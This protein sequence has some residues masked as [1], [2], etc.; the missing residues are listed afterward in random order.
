MIHVCNL[1]TKEADYRI[2][3]CLKERGEERKAK[4]RSEERRGDPAEVL[5]KRY[6]NVYLDRG[7]LFFFLSFFPSLLP[8]FCVSV[9]CAHVCVQEYTLGHQGGVR[10]ITLSYFLERTISH[11]TWS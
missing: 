3:L 8:L 10:S 4:R 7:D 1:S 5:N 9:M 11:W 2:I 6:R